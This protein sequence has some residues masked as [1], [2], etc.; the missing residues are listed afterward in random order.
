[1]MRSTIVTALLLAV[2]TSTLSAQAPPAA[3]PLP[4]GAPMRPALGAGAD[5]NDW[6]AYFDRGAKIFRDSPAEAGAYFYWASRLDPSRAEP[7]FAR[8]ANFLFRAKNEDIYAYLRGDEALWRRADFIGADSLRTRAIMRNPFVHR[9]LESLVYDRLPGNFAESRDTRAWIAYTEGKFSQA[10]AMHTRTIDRGGAKAAWSRYDRALAAVAGGDMALA[11]TDLR[12]LVEELRRR[13]EAELVGFYASKHHLLYMT[14]LVH[15][16]LG[17]RV[18]ARAAMGEST[19]ENAAFAYGWAGLAGLSRAAR[20]HAQAVSEYETAL[21]LEPNDGYLHFLHAAA[22]FDL[23]RYEAAATAAAKATELEPYYAAPHFLLGRSRERQGR[24][25][26]A[27]P[28]FERFVALAPAKD[29]Q[30]KSMKYRL[31]LR[32]KSDTT[33]PRPNDP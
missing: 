13:D 11:L 20:Q 4:A 2:P 21:E 31:E 9:G 33:R 10:V 18:A 7:Y 3:G 16:Q 22:L 5:V 27:Y 1:M 29:P 8:W 24:E 30:A 17:D 12:A 15:N 19:V 25:S 14:A 26:E 23:Q 28:H 6:E 32:A